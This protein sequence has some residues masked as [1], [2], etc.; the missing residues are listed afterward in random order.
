MLNYAL[1]FS[2]IWG[3]ITLFA[4]LPVLSSA[5]SF[6]LRSV[7]VYLFIEHLL[8]TAIR[9]RHGHCPPRVKG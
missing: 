8:C 6:L 1:D 3:M 9:G 7:E 5:L 2:S 4:P